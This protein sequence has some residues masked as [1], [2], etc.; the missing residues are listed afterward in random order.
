MALDKDKGMQAD[1]SPTFT[2][3]PTPSGILEPVSHPIV[4][5]FHV[6]PLVL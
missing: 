4:S 1:L 5:P 2:S 6:Y 3:A